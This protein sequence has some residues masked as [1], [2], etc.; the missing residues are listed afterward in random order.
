LR[1]VLDTVV[2][3]RALLNPRSV[4]GQL[5]RRT[6]EYQLIT[7]RDIAEEL[8]EVTTRSALQQRLAR[9][10]ARTEHAEVVGA[11]RDA[12]VILDVPA[13][14]VCRDAN[15]D[16][17]FACAVAGRADYIVSEDEDVLAVAEYEGV[18][19]IRAAAF[20]KLLDEAAR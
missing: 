20:L 9:F 8:D 18:R 16:I 10:A 1:I 11:L 12:E 15:D 3:V 14:A 17:F 6:G 13:V 19:T 4:W 5:A 2:S 7:S